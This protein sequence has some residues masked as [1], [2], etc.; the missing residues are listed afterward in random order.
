MRRECVAIGIHLPAAEE[1]GVGMVFMPQSSDM[2]AKC[3]NMVEKT[4]VAE[5]LGV[6]G[7]RQVPVNERA[8]AG[9]AR[10]Q[11]P[12]IMQCFVHGKGY[13]SEVL[14]RKLYVLRR[15]I[16]QQTEAVLD[17][18]AHFYIP[19]MSCRTINYKGL[20]TG[21][22]LPQY[23]TDLNDPDLVSAVAVIHQ[24]YSTN[25][26]P[27]WELAQ[28]FRYL[29]H[30]GEINTLRG[31]LN[32]MRSREPSLASYH[33][34]FDIKKLLPIIDERG[35]DSACLDNALELLYNGGRSLGH[36]MLMLVP[37]AWGV[38]YP[39]GPDQRGFFEYHAGLMEPW[40]GPAAA[41]FTDGQQVGAML[42]RNGL[43]PA[44]YTITKKGLMVFASEAGVLDLRPE[45]V[46]EKGALRPG[47]MI[48]VDFGK[49]RVL[50][51]GELKN[52]CARQQPYRRWVEENRIAVRGFYG[53]VASV[54]PDSDRLPTLQKVFGYTREDLQV[55]IK[56]MAIRGQEPVGSMG[57]DTPLAVF[58]EKSQLLYAYFKQLFAQVT[59]PPIDPVREELVMSLM[60]FIG[61]PGNILS[62]VPQ[63]AR[64]IK[65][66]HPILANE[67]L[68]RIRN[69]NLTDFGSTTLS[70]GFQ[71]G[72]AG[73]HLETALERL[74][75]RSEEAIADGK[76]LI[77]LSDRD[78][79]ADQTP[80]PALLGVSAVNQRLIQNGIRTRVG[81]IA[82]TGEAREVMHMALLLGYGATAI[83][84]Y[85]AFETIA[86]MC[87]NGQLT[88]K[89]S[90]AVALEN[91]IQALCKG[92]LKIMSKMGISTLR[93]YRSAQVFQAIGL[94]SDFANRY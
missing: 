73:I 75:D 83:N 79:P 15:Q 40:D 53:D 6:L 16:E 70:M 84:P 58:S 24:R 66:L 44:R 71:A 50:K 32:H 37:E 29:A 8:I 21:L 52:L 41:A 62:E 25:T 56:P 89:V 43:R 67:D 36:A 17:Q 49:Q 76:T 81:V 86:A 65:L 90:V 3:V 2:R 13:A 88:A 51:D 5:G 23:Y 57:A 74:C 47:Q 60:T 7:W 1:Y 93:S 38:K 82:E 33:F 12:A 28:P 10:E 42:D 64:L 4:I 77:I 22:Q 80:I 46:R 59:N 92:L 78:L 94:N 48:M 45:E 19:S 20:L 61:N 31:N 68:R 85:L 35:S 14:E 34:G 69:L 26:F 11:Q 72:G 30:N 55:V 18:D 27:S 91:Y 63:N 87:A 54:K 39:L 9:Q